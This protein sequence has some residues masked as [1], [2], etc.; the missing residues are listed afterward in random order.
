MK[1]KILKYIKGELDPNET[2][3]LMLWMHSDSQNQKMFNVLKA[4]YVASRL[5]DLPDDIEEE[6]T[7]LLKRI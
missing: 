7:P 4:E 1:A 2:E 3:K 6:S 5:K